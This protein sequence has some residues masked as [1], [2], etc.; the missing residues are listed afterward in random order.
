MCLNGEDVPEQWSVAN[1]STIHKK[2]DR[3]DCDVCI[4]VN[5]TFSR[6]NEKVKIRI[7]IQNMKAEEQ[8]SFKAERS[9]VHHIFCLTQ[10]IEKN[11]ATKLHLVFIGLKNDYWNGMHSKK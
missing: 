2:G 7:R 1:L 8:A 9:T 6:I 4:A 11:A 3:C 5:S 10:L